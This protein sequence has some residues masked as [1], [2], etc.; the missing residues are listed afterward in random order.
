M[1]PPPIVKL[2]RI[3]KMTLNEVHSTLAFKACV[4]FGFEM[5][6]YVEN[7]H[8]SQDYIIAKVCMEVY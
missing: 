8:F 6:P 2:M 4:S 3:T 7:N 1:L 5:L